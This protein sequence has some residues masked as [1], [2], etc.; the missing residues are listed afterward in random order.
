MIPDTHQNGEHVLLVELVLPVE[1][2]PASPSFAA[3]DVTTKAFGP[4]C[5]VYF[6]LVIY[7]NMT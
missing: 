1:F 4:P 7:E 5:Q 3:L 2:E 6:N